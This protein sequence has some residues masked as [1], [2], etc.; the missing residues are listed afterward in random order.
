[1]RYR[2]CGKIVGR[3]SATA[4]VGDARMSRPK[5]VSRQFLAA[6]TSEI[7]MPRQVYEQMAHF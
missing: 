3:E 7:R 6:K 4:D 2:M 5:G 1:M